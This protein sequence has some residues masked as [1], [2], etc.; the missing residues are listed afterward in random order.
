MRTYKLSRNYNIIEDAKTKY[1][2]NI[3]EVAKLQESNE[4]HG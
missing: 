4:R 3:K 2:A 1:D